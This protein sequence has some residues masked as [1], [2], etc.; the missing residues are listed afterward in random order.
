V[1][2]SEVTGDDVPAVLAFWVDCGFVESEN[3]DPARDL[4]DAM[5][6]DE[7]TVLVGRLGASICATAMVDI[8]AHVGLVY[9]LGVDP[10]HRSL[11]LGRQMMATAER[12]LRQRGAR[13]LQLL[14]DDENVG[15]LHFYERLGLHRIP[16]TTMGKTL[17]D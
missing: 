9:Y 3:D 5:A 7:A 2:V 1:I 17:T 12:W 8:D 15:A 16:V 14:V 13:E 10:S 6:S 4:R 11:G